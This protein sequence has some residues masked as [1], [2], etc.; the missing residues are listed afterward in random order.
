MT[1]K[2]QFSLYDAFTDK[3]LGGS[4]GGVIVTDGEL[5]TELRQNIAFE[6]GAAATAFV[7]AYD[8]SSITTRFHSTITEYGMCGHGTLCMITQMLEDEV[9]SWS[10]KEYLKLDL[11]LPSTTACVEIYRNKDNLAQIMLDIKAAKFEKSDSDLDRLAGLLS[12][13]TDD[14]DKT[15][16]IE[17]A[18]GDFTHLVV[19]ISGLD[20]MSSIKP[21]FSGLVKFC[22][23]FGIQTVAC[24]SKETVD[25]NNTIHVRDFCPAVGVNESAA[26]GTTNAAL[27]AYLFRNNICEKNETQGIIN[28]RAEQGIEMK[29]PSLVHS[30]LH[31]EED[32]IKRIQVGGVAVK[33]ISG[34]MFLDI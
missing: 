7:S 11:K 12:I 18:R 13:G 28:I 33:T 30:I 21:D 15:V 17:L 14:F 1:K 9:F 2:I 23:E 32:E 27:S 22:H 26:A 34:N 16:P 31:Y 8:A 24:F 4:Q 5:D 19:P 6:I 3:A 10:D 29:R 20:V 25:K